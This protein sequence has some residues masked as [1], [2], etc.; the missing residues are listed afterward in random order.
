MNWVR[1]RSLDCNRYYYIYTCLR[2]V[3]TVLGIHEL[4]NTNSQDVNWRYKYSILKLFMA[5]GL[6][7][8][9]IGFRRGPLFASVLIGLIVA[10]GAGV[11][12]HVL[13]VGVLGLSAYALG[14][15]IFPSSN[16]AASDCLLAGIAIFGTVLGLLVQFPINNPGSWGL[17]FALPLIAARNHVRDLLI[18]YRPDKSEG[19]HAYLVY[20]AIGAIA[21][22]H[23]LVTLMPEQGHDALA[24][25]MAVPAYINYFQHWSFDAGT[26]VWA[27]MPMLV[28]WL[29]SAGYMFAGE[30]GARLVNFSSILLIAL[31]VYR[32]AFWMR[33]N[34]VTAAWAVLFF[35]SH[36]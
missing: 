10:I 3:S 14:R 11:F 28:D 30:T 32:I 1:Q 18:N 17:L 31:L 5:F 12:F 34:R 23:L 7:I 22:V 36:L 20:C 8:G 27:V 26:Y 2:A 29:Y 16:V 15:L 24:V 6:I 33:A 4:S 21:L 25:H 19:L 9:A 35:L 13:A